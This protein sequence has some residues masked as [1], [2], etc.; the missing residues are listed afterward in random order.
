VA[1]GVYPFWSPD[2]RSI[3][4]F[5]QDKLQVID[6][7]N[8]SP[9][10]IAPA[11]SLAPGGTWGPGG[12]I[13]Y[14]M[15]MSGPLFR[16]DAAGGAPVQVTNLNIAAGEV[17]H[18][19]PVFLPDGRQFLFLSQ[20]ANAAESAVV[21]GSLDSNHTT[22]LV[23]TT[24]QPVFAPPH[25]LLFMRE[26]A[27]LAQQ[28]DLRRM[29]LVGTPAEVL[30]AVLS[31]PATG[32]VAARVSQ[33]GVLA[34]RR[35][36]GERR[37]LT[38]LDRAGR[39]ERT[40]GTPELYQNPRLSPDGTRLAVHRRDPDDDIWILDLDRGGSTR[41]TS[42]A[43][44]DNDPLWSPD[45]TQIA[46]V[47]NRDGGVFNIYVKGSGGV[48][49][50]EVLLLKSE[51]N[52]RLQDWSADGRY[53]LYEQSDAATRGDLWI[54]PMTGDRTP[55][56]I[57]GSRFHEERASFSPDGRWIAYTSDESGAP[58]VYVQA[59]P[60]AGTKW[61]VS[62]TTT[63][64]VGPRF[65]ADG[66]ELFFD[67]SGQMMSVDLTGTVPGKMFSAG[68]PRRL[69]QGLMN[70]QPHS[71]DVTS[72]GDRFV[73]VTLPERIDQGTAGSVPIT[74]ETHWQPP[75]PR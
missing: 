42:D 51:A 44:I 59:F 8:G 2:S 73:I 27:L 43:A 70:L 16:V 61:H 35:G 14:A 54:L 67:S 53:I 64:G 36:S 12:T 25:W 26:S 40:L 52:K 74:I 9:R 37:I 57:L 22:R 58:H 11:G 31:N 69:F 62:S 20:N 24:G 46:F 33:T 10:T 13:L 56:R 49:Q 17:S 39:T 19:H 34:Y 60:D 28:L 66:K 18:R 55:R 71:Y 21:A 1:S 3:G 15:S 65:R 48:D 32:T 6:L 50:S 29:A 45:G 30:P 5:M 38:W 4:F 72:S 23:E 68:V 7:P 47:S 41:F 63:R 75:R